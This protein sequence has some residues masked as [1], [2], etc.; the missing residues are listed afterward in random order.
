MKLEQVPPRYRT[1]L[2]V[3]DNGC[4]LWTGA[5]SQGYGYVAIFRKA[6]RVHR[7]LFELFVGPV[8]EGFQLHHKCEVRACCNPDHLAVLNQ[9]DHSARHLS[10]H[11]ARGHLLS[12]ENV[13][14]VN[15]RRRQCKRCKKASY[16]KKKEQKYG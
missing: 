12:E 15:G 11:C 5:K 7:L 6:T 8:P 2:K 14:K 3:D 9:L 10:T 13:I 1:R 4:W 16:V